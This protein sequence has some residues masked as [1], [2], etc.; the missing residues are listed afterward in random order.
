[1]KYYDIVAAAELQF[2]CEDPVP[3]STSSFRGGNISAVQCAGSARE[4]MKGPRAQS[5]L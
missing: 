4:R 1:M 2:A 3:A 5:F